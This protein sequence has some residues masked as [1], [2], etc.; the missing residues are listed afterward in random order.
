MKNA[1]ASL[2]VYDA[3]EL[4]A[5]NVPGCPICKDASNHVFTNWFYGIV[6]DWCMFVVWPKKQILWMGCLTDTD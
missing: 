4:I 3:Y 5:G 6:W 1:L 2:G